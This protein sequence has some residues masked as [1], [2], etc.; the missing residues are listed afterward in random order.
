MIV[1]LALL[2]ALAGDFDAADSAATPAAKADVLLPLTETEDTAAEAWMRL[3]TTFLTTGKLPL[4]SLAYAEALRLDPDIEGA[5]AALQIADG[6]GDAAPVAL[7]MQ[8]RAKAPG[9]GDQQSAN[10]VIVAREL[11]RDGQLTKAE[12]WLKRVSAD[13]PAF[14]D[15]EA[16]RGVVLAAKGQNAEALAPLQTARA[17]GK[18]LEKGERFDEK[19]VMNIAR[20]YYGDKNYGQAIYHYSLVPRDSIYWPE[21]RF[22]KAWAHFRAGDVPGTIGELQTHQSPFFD[23]LW[24]PEAWMLRTQ[25]LFV[26]CRYGAAIEGMDAYEARFQ[27]VLEDLDRVLGTLDANGAYTAVTTYLDGQATDVPELVLRSYRAEDR[28]AEARKAAATYTTAAGST[29][30]LGANAD[31]FAKMLTDRASALQSR[32]GKRVLERI[33][34]DRKELADMISGLELARIDILDRESRMFERAAA[35]GV[36]EQPDRKA[37]LKRIAREKKGYRVWPFQGEYWADEL[38]WY[39]VNA[40]SLCPPAK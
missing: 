12:A 8:D 27:P 25:S 15:S 16:I 32:E 40:L 24:F 23:E 17:M 28:I 39:Q 7:A 29:S 20:A 36:L 18:S 22:E 30:D 6:L 2:S 13:S 14:A 3:A 31:H 37:E 38:G 10:A 26:M 9:T 33:G 19:L 5:D 34:R 4:A 21:A 35:T 1:L 11:L